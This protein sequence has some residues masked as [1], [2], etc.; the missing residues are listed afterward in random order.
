VDEARA[1]VR[2]DFAALGVGATAGEPF[3]PWVVSGVGAGE[4]AAIG[5]APRAVGILEEVIAAERPV[6]TSSL[7]AHAAFLGTPPRRP[8]MKSFL[9]VPIRYQGENRGNL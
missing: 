2:A 8:A 9:G 3:D 1:I 5:G 4:I 7:A 6:R